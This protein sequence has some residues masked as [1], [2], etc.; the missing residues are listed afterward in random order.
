MLTQ[1]KLSMEQFSVTNI[2]KIQVSE[3]TGS[4]PAA[5]GI[6]ALMHSLKA[7]QKPIPIYNRKLHK[8]VAGEENEVTN[9]HYLP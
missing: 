9:R 1:F 4:E 8:Y 2:A 5:V 6:S 3:H 7:L